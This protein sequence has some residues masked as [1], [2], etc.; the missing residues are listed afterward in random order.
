M[1]ILRSVAALA[2]ALTLIATPA[3]ATHE[4]PTANDTVAT[5]TVI[6][7]LP[8]WAYGDTYDA[9]DNTDDAAYPSCFEH[10]DYSVWFQYT[11]TADAEVVLSTMYSGFDTVM[12][13]FQNSEN[14]TCNDDA[15]GDYGSKVNV[16]VTAGETYLIRVAG[17]GGDSGPFQ[18]SAEEFI[19]MEA[20]L[21]VADRGSLRMNSG[22]AVVQATVECNQDGYAAIEFA[23][24]QLT[25]TGRRSRWVDCGETFRVRINSRN[26]EFLPGPMEIDWS[27][28]AC[29]WDA[30]GGYVVADTAEG[31]EGMTATD[32][33]GEPAADPSCMELAGSKTV[34]LI[35]SQ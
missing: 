10:S 4:A 25:G 18:F 6:D 3:S 32:H 26:G 13:V 2:L 28:Y 20:S 34:L 31:G 27:G 16:P 12:D 24:S 14:I 30:Y 8:F 19:P 21:T 29:R 35:P 1:K 33:D 7:A 11:A 23:G 5:A 9:V 17:Y 15:A 22:R